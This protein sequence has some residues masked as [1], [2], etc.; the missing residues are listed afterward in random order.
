MRCPICRDEQFYFGPETVRPVNTSLL[1]IIDCCN[2]KE[3]QFTDEIWKQ[4]L[5]SVDLKL[6]SIKK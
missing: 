2:K 6:K 1:A 3:I 4:G 5:S